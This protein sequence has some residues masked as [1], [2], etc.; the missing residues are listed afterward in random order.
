MRRWTLHVA[1]NVELL[2]PADREAAALA[3]LA[4][5][6]RLGRL[7][8]AGGSVIDLRVPGRVTVRP[9]GA[10]RKDAGT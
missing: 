2:L 6:P 7:V 4:A 10:L 5:D 3:E 8:A 9:A 1:G